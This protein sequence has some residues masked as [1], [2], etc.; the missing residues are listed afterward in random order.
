MQIEHRKD[1]EEKQQEKGQKRRNDRG[2]K[3]RGAKGRERVYR[4]RYF[5]RIVVERERERGGGGIRMIYSFRPL[6]LMKG[7]G[8]MTYHLTVHTIIV[9]MSKKTN[10]LTTMYLH[11]NMFVG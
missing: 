7:C 2:K 11:S 9:P 8:W 4:K 5:P 10:K 6:A 3:R 1:E